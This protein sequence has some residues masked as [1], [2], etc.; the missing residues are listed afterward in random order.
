MLI[1]QS[2][3]AEDAAESSG[4]TAQALRTALIAGSAAQ[5]GSRRVPSEEVDKAFGMPIGKLRARAGIESLA[6]AADGETELALGTRAAQ[7]ALSACGHSAQDLDWIIATSETHQTYPSF[8]AQLHAKLSARQSCGA[9]DVGG[10]CLGLLNAL[11][12]AQSL[13]V[14]CQAR[15]IAV[16]TADVHSRT[17]IPSRVA[18]E[19]GGLFGDGASAF[20]LHSGEPEAS[21][22][23]YRLNQFLFGCVGQ[24]SGAVTVASGLDG[25]LDV[26]FDGES[27]SR[28]AI[29]RIEQVITAVE[30]RSGIDRN[31]VGAFATHQPNPRLLSLI[32]KFA[33]I[34]MEAFPPIARTCGNLGPSTCGAA[35]HAAI[36][37]CNRY[38]PRER[39]PIFLVSLGPGLLYGGSWLS[40]SA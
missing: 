25:A 32:A 16:V 2:H 1:S 38:G 24:Y 28:A 11:A 27:L 13:I 15:T 3:P 7:L 14:S 34:P 33:G 6:Y 29:T 12:V 30:E 17:L 40:F 22:S 9:L 37:N 31:D 5:F 18:G 23:A 10:A 20:L 36:H 4:R 26:H 35:L 21:S 39:K 19:F 8:S